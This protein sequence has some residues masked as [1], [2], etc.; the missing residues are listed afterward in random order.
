MIRSRMPVARVGLAPDNAVTWLLT[1]KYITFLVQDLHFD[2]LTLQSAY[3]VKR[4]SH[5]MLR[6]S[7]SNAAL[8]LVPE[9]N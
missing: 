4:L 9:V 6:F 5:L 1:G 7:E 3:A 8:G 2:P